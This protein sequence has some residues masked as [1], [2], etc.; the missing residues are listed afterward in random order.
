MCLSGCFS[1]HKL[2]TTDLQKLMLLRR[3]VFG[4]VTKSESILLTLDFEFRPC[5]LKSMQ[6]AGFRKYLHLKILK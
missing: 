2:K 5:E 1:A 6:C 3:I 4:A